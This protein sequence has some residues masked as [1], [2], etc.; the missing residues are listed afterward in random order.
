MV[1]RLN[2][3]ELN[4]FLRVPF[5]RDTLYQKQAVVRRGQLSLQ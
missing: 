4:V 1:R 3:D 2:V 5:V